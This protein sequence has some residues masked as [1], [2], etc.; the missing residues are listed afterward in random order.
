MRTLNPSIA[1]LLLTLHTGLV[2]SSAQA[3]ATPAHA[4]PST[5]PQAAPAAAPVAP[6]PTTAPLPTAEQLAQSDPMLA[7]LP[8][9]AHQLK[10][11]REALALLRGQNT[12]L[13]I[14]R[15][16]IAEA[17]A[18]SRDALSKAL[19][20]LTATGSVNH[21]LL[22]GT[23]TRLSSSGIRSNVRI[24]DPGTTWQ[25]GVGLRQPVIDYKSWYDIGTGN[26]RTRVAEHQTQNTERQ[27]LGEVAN[28]LVDLVTAE[29]LLEISRESLLSSLALYNLTERRA[30]LG[31]GSRLDVLRAEQNVSQS[32]S[33]LVATQ[34]AV[35]QA[36]ESLGMALGFPQ[37]WGI[38]P[39]IKLDS[40]AADARQLCTQVG[41]VADR[42]DVRAALANSQAAERDRKSANYEGLPTLD[43]VSDLTVT[44]QDFTAN[45]KPVQW[46]IGGLLTIPLYDG[47]SRYAAHDRAAANIE[48]TRQ[49]LT[50][51]K[52]QAE[53]EVQRANRAVGVAQTTLQ[54]S[55]K[56]RDLAKETAR[57]AQVAFLNG[58]GTSFDL[59]DTE[60]QHREAELDLAIK[61]LEVLRAGIAALLAQANCDI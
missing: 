47:G 30:A 17:R 28:T 53:L 49:E 44:S 20:T 61:E 60:R 50:Q 29:R 1:G 11:W 18:S 21:H 56:T 3:Q 5:S 22:Y 59:V 40:L 48:I 41:T 12:S 32:R 39:A 15:A 10:S 43:F 57:L 16:R 36:R 54:V 2:A 13:A 46:T 45:N 6:S 58:S 35:L 26:D 14:S 33:Q 19:P 4:A 8:P 31:A 52:R 27:L 23:G 55:I 24:P 9:A 37:G 42:A 25:A 7:P 38:D 51:V 34:E